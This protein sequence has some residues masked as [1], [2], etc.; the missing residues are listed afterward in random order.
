NSRDGR[1]LRRLGVTDDGRAEDGALTGLAFSPGGAL[2]VSGSDATR[3]V[4]VREAASGRLLADRFVGGGRGNAAF[5]PHGRTLAVA[6]D[7]RTLLYEIGGLREHGLAAQQPEQI[8]A[9]A[10][11]PDGRHLLCLSRSLWLEELADV[12]AWPLGGQP[13]AAPAARQ[14]VA[15]GKVPAGG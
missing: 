2:L 9:C 6:A 10:L 15:V 1:L 11:H 7:R 3:H 5:S 12:T 4:K 13:A 14:T 8:S